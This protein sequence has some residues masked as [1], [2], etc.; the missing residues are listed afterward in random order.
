MDRVVLVSVEP[1]AIVAEALPARERR[2]GGNAVSCGLGSFVGAA[3]VLAAVATGGVVSGGLCPYICHFLL[4]PH[5]VKL[6]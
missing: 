5:H 1:T 4:L 6:P 3:K 2:A